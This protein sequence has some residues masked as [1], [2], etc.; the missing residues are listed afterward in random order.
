MNIRDRLGMWSD[1]IK[2]YINNKFSQNWDQTPS[3]INF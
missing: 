3:G 1:G 2:N